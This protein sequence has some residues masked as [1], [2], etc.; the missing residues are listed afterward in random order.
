MKLSIENIGIIKEA[1]IN[2]NGLTVIC[3]ENDTGKS[4]IGKSLFALIKGIVGFEEEFQEDISYELFN[5]L[6][7]LNRLITSN[8]MNNDFLQENQNEI[9]EKIYSHFRSPS[10]L[11]S[12]SMFINKI[13]LEDMINLQEIIEQLKENKNIDIDTYNQFSFYI[14]QCNEIW[15]Q[16][17]DI[18][19]KQKKAIEKAFFSEFQSLVMDNSKI[20]LNLE[21]FDT[22]LD[23]TFNENCKIENST[24][25]IN[26]YPWRDIT[27]IE[28]P[29]IIQFFKLILGARVN[30]SESNRAR[31]TVPLHTKDLTR[32]LFNSDAFGISEE[33][34]VIHETIEKAIQGNFYYDKKQKDFILE[35]NKKSIPSMDIASGIKSLGMID[36]LVKNNILNIDDILILDEPEINLHP[37]WQ[38]L[39][40]EIICKLVKLGIKV[41]VV[42]HSP[43]MVS[44]LHYYS[45]DNSEIMRN[46]YL[47]KKKDNGI[48]FSDETD[49]V[50]GGIIKE[51]ALAYEGIY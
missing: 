5:N 39:Y 35:R 6:R 26:Y 27:Y 19:K 40:A 46:F 3:G 15:E 44:A 4:T 1:S 29:T 50:M 34:N 41:L 49:N 11:A 20:S 21:E 17:L 38:K 14:H 9:L 2:I 18:D 23:I 8:I 37:E 31:E 36:I 32:K 28:T 24:L 22:Y 51:F 42:T 12:S 13:I 45:E 43:Y 25:N 33:F 10:I 48:Y 7:Q 30:L 47:S 16:N